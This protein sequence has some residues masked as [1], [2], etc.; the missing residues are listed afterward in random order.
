MKD[1]TFT[2]CSSV[3]DGSWPS[4]LKL[5]SD[6]Y[7]VTLLYTGDKGSFA[8]DK[9]DGCLDRSHITAMVEVKDPF[10]VPAIDVSN[11]EV[12]VDMGSLCVSKMSIDHAR[13]VSE[14]IKLA[15]DS[16]LELH[17]LISEIF[18]ERD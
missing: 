16:A 14:G 18:E 5:S 2:R 6:V 17:A 8:E 3:F 1:V 11:G 4:V 7:D 13:S 9:A 12:V 10:S 15:I